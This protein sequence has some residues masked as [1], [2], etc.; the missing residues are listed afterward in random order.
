MADSETLKANSV[1]SPDE[2]R[3]FDNGKVDIVSLDEV[4]AGRFTLEPGWRWSANVKPIVGTD[5]CQVL[6]SQ[7]LHTGYVISGRMHLVHDDG[8]EQEVGPWDVYTIRPGQ[9]YSPTFV[10]GIFSEVRFPG[11]SISPKLTLRPGEFIMNSSASATLLCAGKMRG[12]APT[13]KGHAYEE[14]RSGVY[15]LFPLMTQGPRAWS[16]W[17]CGCPQRGEGE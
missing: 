3:T 11:Q 8:S 15:E 16:R 7:V 9:D 10:V 1:E 5:S 4:T 13:R 12:G 14:R 6:H 17:V 2:T